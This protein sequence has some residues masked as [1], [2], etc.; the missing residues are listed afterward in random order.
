M[1]LLTG[2]E[3]DVALAGLDGWLLDDG[4][5]VGKFRRTSWKDALAFVNAIGDEA[6]RR[7]HHPDL[8]ITG[9]RTVTVRLTTHSDGGVTKRDVSLAQW[10]A[11]AAPSPD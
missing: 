1:T 11:E 3:L 7:N 6:E 5:L 8:C 9:Y 2:T 4:V 10:I